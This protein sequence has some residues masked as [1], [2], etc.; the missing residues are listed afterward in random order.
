MKKSV[1]GRSLHDD[2]IIIDALEISNWSKDV[3]QMMRVGGLT[4][5]N[6]TISVL[7]NFRQT[8][9]N[10]T[11][12]HRWFDEY[13]DTII[14]VMTT[15]DIK[16]AK[17]K[18]KTGIIFG[19]QNTSGIEDDLDLLAIFNKLGVRI[20]QITYNETNYVG[21]GCLERYDAGLT[22]FGLEVVEEMNRLGI[23]I[24]LSHVGD[25]TTMETIEASQ[26]PVAFTHA[27]ARSL[28]EYPRN[29]TD[30]QL[31]ALVKKGGVIGANSFPSFLPKGYG[32]TI[33][34][35][36]D[37]IDYL[38]DLVGI[39]H[40]GIGTDFTDNQ[41]KA[42]FDW[43]TRGRSK[44]KAFMDIDYPVI[45]PKGFRGAAD[46]PNLTQALLERGYV[47]SDVKKIM[48]ENMFRLFKEVWES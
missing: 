39:D 13:S 20:I 18:G 35:Y 1:N 22:A 29:K 26:K 21:T 44:R 48:G 30:E 47:E 43:I 27:N 9:N 33:K 12:W 14:H 16:E 31:K 2:S 8:I 34:D 4:A 25:M 17:K 19:F 11:Q 41:S 40:V 45:Y 28:Y 3:F 23:L 6:T 42:F 36:I 10:I 46:F 32:S 5:V 15:D 7:E 37:T 38:V 24:D